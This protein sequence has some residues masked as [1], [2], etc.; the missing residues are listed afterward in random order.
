MRHF[1]FLGEPPSSSRP[2]DVDPSSTFGQLQYLIAG[3]F[4]IVSP[5]GIIETPPWEFDEQNPSNH[6]QALLYIVRPL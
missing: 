4:A 6:H 3:F 5:D 1:Y 2:L